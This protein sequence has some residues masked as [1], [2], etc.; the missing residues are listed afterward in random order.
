M[1]IGGECS[2][3]RSKC[4]GSFFLESCNGRYKKRTSV[5]AKRSYAQPEPA[6][7]ADGH[8]IQRMPRSPLPRTFFATLPILGALLATFAGVKDWP[9]PLS[10][11]A[12]TVIASACALIYWS[13]PLSEGKSGGAQKQNSPAA[14]I[15]EVMLAV[16]AA[17]AQPE[18]QLS[19]SPSGVTSSLPA[20]GS[21]G[22]R[23]DALV[24]GD[25]HET[26]LLT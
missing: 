5:C 2:L 9:L 15:P 4:A 14:F 13:A 19:P 26:D 6:L 20:A 11:L 22:T 3:C 25:S 16:A 17:T 24:T 8:D 12:M 21:I 18:D 10:L 23:A 1:N 7:Y